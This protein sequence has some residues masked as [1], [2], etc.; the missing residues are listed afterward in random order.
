MSRSDLPTIDDLKLAMCWF[1][2]LSAAEKL[3]H[4][5]RIARHDTISIARYWVANI[6]N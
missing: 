1:K 3:H 6:K 2:A 4:R 5:K